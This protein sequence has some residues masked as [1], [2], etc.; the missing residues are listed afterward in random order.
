M[1]K[2]ALKIF[3]AA[4][5]LMLI[6]FSF[7]AYAAEG[8]AVLSDKINSVSAFN[9]VGY[10]TISWEKYPDALS[11]EVQ[12]SVNDGKWGKVYSVTDSSFKDKNT[13]NGNIYTYRVRA[14]T[15]NGK[16]AYS[17]V[18]NMYLG[19][20]VIKSVKS[21]AEGLSVKWKRCTVP[22]GYLVY[23]K[24]EGEKEYTLIATIKGN[25]PKY[26]D[27]KVSSGKKYSY[28]IKQ[29]SGEYTSAYKEK[30]TTATFIAYVKKLT[31]SNSPKGVMLNW[32]AVKGAKGYSVWRKTGDKGKWKKI[33]TV[34]T[35]GG[36]VYNDKTTA[37]GKKNYY[38]VRAWKSSK[39]YG[40]YSKEAFLYSVNP[41][42]PMVALTYDDGP[43][44]PATNRILDTLE[45][46]ESR[47]TFFVVGSR[48][49]TYADCIRREASLGC[50]I[51]N[52]TFSHPILTTCGPEV[53]KEEISKTDKLIK[54]YSGKDVRL[55]RAPGGAVS[56]KVRE[57]VKHPLVNWSVDTLDWDHR[58]ASKTL[59]S[60]KARAFDGAIIL[61]HDL[62]LPT[63]AA[64]EEAIPYLVSKG[65]QLVTVSEMFEAKG[66][67][68]EKGVLYTRG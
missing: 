42:K 22:T 7:S 35:K 44:A 18:S 45:K 8:E 50:E 55:V 26:T 62:Y 5:S 68:P 16:S 9:N 57:N 54:K 53:I 40:A 67:V 64:S 51:A 36:C 66:I 41:N 19:S 25:T 17:T 46:Y 14:V 58:T 60:I 3:L 39:V 52:H 10:M 24:A 4:A 30:G 47:A 33:G 61:M 32:K 38:R 65:Y 49:D 28:K 48:V 20:P 27:K 12:R 21:T 6:F 59:S 43:Y 23:R 11:Y 34:K 37:Y 31:A 2:R 15:E 1:M 63:A 29:I 56:D 13:K